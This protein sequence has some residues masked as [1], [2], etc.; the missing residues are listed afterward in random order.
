MLSANA[1]LE[2]F[3]PAHAKER[4][5]SAA[6]R[7]LNCTASIE[8]V[9]LYPNDDSE[10][11]LKG[12]KVHLALENSI[13]FGITPDTDDPDADMNVRDVME[14]VAEQRKI[15]GPDTKVYAERQYDI[16][17]I[18]SY[19]TC[20]LTLVA[21][22]AIHI[23]DYKNGYVM[24]DAYEQMMTYLLGAIAEFGERDFYYITVIQPNYNHRDGPYRTSVIFPSD[25]RE[26]KDRVA[27]AMNMKYYQAGSWCKK[28]YCPHRGACATFLAWA[29]REGEDAYYSH[30]VN[31]ITDEQL[32]TALDHADTLHGIR[33]E[34]RKEAMRRMAQH[35]R[36]IKGYKLVKS[37]IN[38]EFAGEAG[39]DQCHVALLQIGYTQE[40]FM[41]KKPFKVAGLTM[42]ET[43]PLTVP[44]IEK[45]V[46]QKYKNFGNGKWKAIWDEYF[47]PH[48]REYSGSLTLER[49]TDG[50]PAHTRGSEFG[51]INPAPNVNTLKSK[52]VI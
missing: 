21:P 28:T 14:W 30:E 23:G 15:L 32:A 24:T 29:K 8:V 34:H 22:K 7:W 9:P 4:P 43:V 19:G 27:H 36:S 40:N 2:G 5:P 12:D 13:L 11:S 52:Q 18:N 31:A 45:M 42:Y 49:D 26:F 10:A 33:D 44:A 3:R 48:I 1:T 17:E 35:G 47:R 50:R 51:S 20:D 25:I 37:R 38:R 6:L 46:K 16:A 41:E 39:R